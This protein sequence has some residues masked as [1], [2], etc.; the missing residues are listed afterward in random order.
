MYSIQLKAI[1]NDEVEVMLI[2][3]YPYQAPMRLGSA[4]GIAQSPEAIK[5]AMLTLVDTYAVQV[6]KLSQ[7]W[8]DDIAALA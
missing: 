4:D 6:P 7:V 5:A 3:R 1:D 2:A 8:A